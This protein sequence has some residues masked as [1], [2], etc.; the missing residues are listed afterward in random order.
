MK[1]EETTAAKCNGLPY[2]MAIIYTTINFTS[3]SVT[4][5]APYLQLARHGLGMVDTSLL[6]AVEVRVFTHVHDNIQTC[7]V[8]DIYRSRPIGASLLSGR[9]QHATVSA[10]LLPATG[11]RQAGLAAAVGATSLK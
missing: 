9:G 5:W 7:R 6:R 11:A 8:V 1:K 10:S 3:Y 4:E 2:W